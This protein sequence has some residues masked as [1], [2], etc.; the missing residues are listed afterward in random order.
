MSTWPPRDVPWYRPP[1]R[2]RWWQ[3]LG[4]VILGMLLLHVL[5]L[6]FIMPYRQGV[7]NAWNR[8]AMKQRLDA[9][10]RRMEDEQRRGY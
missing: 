6:T 8:S 10:I 5:G 4:C 2:P 3:V 9:N 7:Q 1:Q